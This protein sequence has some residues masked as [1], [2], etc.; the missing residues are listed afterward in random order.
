MD[1]SLPGSSIHGIFKARVLELGA[2]A[3]SLED[4]VKDKDWGFWRGLHRR[5]WHSP[6]V[7]NCGLCN[8]FCFLAYC[9]C[10]YCSDSLW[11]HGLQHTRPL[12]LPL[13]PGVFCPLSGSCPLSW[14]YYLTISS[15]VVPFLL[16]SVFPSIMVFSNESTLHIMWPTYWSFSFSIRPSNEYSGLVFFRFYWLDLLAV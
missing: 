11:L 1:C 10:C 2:I 14:W 4:V 6:T 3:F 13:C 12:C 5:A 8:W 15:S 16:L 7:V 9:Y